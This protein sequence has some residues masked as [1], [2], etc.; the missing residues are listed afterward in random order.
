MRPLVLAAL[1]GLSFGPI[2]LANPEQPASMK[3]VV[4]TDDG[5]S[6]EVRAV[7]EDHIAQAVGTPAPAA[8]A[9]DRFA[10]PVSDLVS[11][12]PTR[13]QAKAACRSKSGPA[14]GRLVEGEA[15]R[16]CAN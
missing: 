1:I 14:S 12:P 11:V 2:A 5:Y 13:D 3:P 10:A 4:K 16:S 15:K 8:L 7:M 9:A 6:R